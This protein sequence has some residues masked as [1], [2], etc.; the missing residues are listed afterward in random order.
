MEYLKI[1]F[2]WAFVF[3]AIHASWAW[4]VAAHYGQPLVDFLLKIHFLNN[5]FVVQSFDLQLGFILAGLSGIFGLIAGAASAFFID[6][7]LND[8]FHRD[9][10]ENE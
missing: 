10:S 6:L 4:I 5:P 2:V 8:P 7:F 9:G 3:S 1:G